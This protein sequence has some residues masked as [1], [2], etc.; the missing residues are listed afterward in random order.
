MEFR[1]EVSDKLGDQTI[2]LLFDEIRNGSVGSAKIRL[3]SKK[4]DGNPYVIVYYSDD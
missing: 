4:M 3:I 2:S 1:R